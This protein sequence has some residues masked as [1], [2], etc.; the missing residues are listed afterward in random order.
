MPVAAYAIAVL[1]VATCTSAFLFACAAAPAIAISRASTTYA[2]AFVATAWALAFIAYAILPNTN[3]P[4]T[5][6]AATADAATASTSTFF[7]M[8]WCCSLM[9]AIKIVAAIFCCNYLCVKIL[10][11]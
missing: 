10:P 9:V 6:I 4:I 1:F 8:A 5:A 2:I 11:Q 3:W 7:W